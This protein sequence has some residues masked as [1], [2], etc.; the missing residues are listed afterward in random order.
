VSGAFDALDRSF[1][2]FA[3]CALSARVVRIC[4]PVLVDPC[5]G[6]TR[7]NSWRYPIFMAAYLFAMAYV[8]SWI[9]YRVATAL[10]S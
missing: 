4:A 10:L 1:M 7:T 5:Y 2:E 6:Q 9:T 3:D 8:G